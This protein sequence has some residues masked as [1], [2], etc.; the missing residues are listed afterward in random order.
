[1][2]IFAIILAGVLAGCAGP[3]NRPLWHRIDGAFQPR[4]C[5]PFARDACAVLREIGIPAQRVVYKWVRPDGSSGY[6]AIVLYNICG[7]EYIV[8]NFAAAP[9][10][11]WGDSLLAKVQFFDCLAVS[12]RLEEPITP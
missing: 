1:M 8:E 5:V 7:R 9:K 12:A 6:H 2:K 11:V 3:T 4:Q 10:E